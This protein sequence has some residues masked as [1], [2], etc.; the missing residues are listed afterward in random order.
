MIE[1]VQE[2]NEVEVVEVDDNA[3]FQ[4]DQA[5]ITLYALLGS[6]SPG[7]M[8][9]LGQIKGY[10]VVILLDTR[11]SYNFLDFVLVRTLQL[12]MDTT[13]IL[14]VR[15]ANGDLIRTK[16]ECKDL[17]IKMQGKY[18]LVDLHVLTL[19]GCDVVLGTQ[20]LST[21]GLI[22]WD[23]KQLEMEFM[24]QGMKVWLQGIKSTGSVIQ[25]GGQFLKQSDKKGCFCKLC[26]NSH[27]YH[28]QNNFFHQRCSLCWR[29]LL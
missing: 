11:S 12:A 5:D 2:V 29:N 28:V 27:R 7:T 23:F 10:W 19:G 22:S 6:P 3:K 15:V 9:V 21:L 24:Y 4:L 18:F 16:G 17:L 1:E 25:D 20:W 26:H 8:R 14:E 13:R